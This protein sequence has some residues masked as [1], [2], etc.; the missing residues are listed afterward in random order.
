MY[1]LSVSPLGI[2]KVDSSYLL[3]YTIGG[4]FTMSWLTLFVHMFTRCYWF[5]RFIIG[6]ACSMKRREQMV[7]SELVG[8]RSGRTISSGL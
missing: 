3:E 8:G 2:R 5:Y 7:L 6:D 4:W 1:Y